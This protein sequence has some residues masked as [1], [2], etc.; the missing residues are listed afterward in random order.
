MNISEANVHEKELKNLRAA[1]IITE[2]EYVRYI[3]NLNQQCIPDYYDLCMEIRNIL[4]ETAQ[5]DYK[6]FSLGDTIKYTPSE[7]AEILEKYKEQ[8]LP[9]L[10]DGV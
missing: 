4:I 8:L 5:R 6:K 7:V 9:F 2:D 3:S 1:N 10:K